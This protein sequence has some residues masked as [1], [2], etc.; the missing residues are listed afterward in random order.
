LALENN[1]KNENGRKRIS[2]NHAFRQE[3]N[4]L[5]MVVLLQQPQRY[6]GAG[7][8]LLSPTTFEKGKKK[9]S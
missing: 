9:Y 7:H 8:L 5:T 1:N 4:I 6:S 2:S 3:S